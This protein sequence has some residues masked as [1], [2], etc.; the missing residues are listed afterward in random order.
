MSAIVKVKKQRNRASF[1][2][3]K[4]KEKKIKCDRSQPCSNC[5]KSRHPENCTYTYKVVKSKENDNSKTS[6]KILQIIDTPDSNSKSENT[7]PGSSPKIKGVNTPEKDEN[8]FLGFNADSKMSILHAPLDLQKS[9]LI[10]RKPSRT[11]SI[12]Y[13]F[14]VIKKCRLPSF[15]RSFKTYFDNERDIW[16]S[17]H[18]NRKVDPLQTLMYINNNDEISS[19]LIKQIEDL[20]CNNYYAVLERLNYFQ[21]HLNEVLF[22]SYIPM[23]V[24]QLIFHHYFIMKPEG[25]QFKHVSKNFEYSFIAL[26]A[27]IVSLTDVFTKNGFPEFNFTLTCGSSEYDELTINLLNSFNF[28]KKQSVFIVYTLLNLRLSLMV[29]GNTQSN[30]MIGQN[31]F[32]YFQLAVNIAQEI[33]LNLDQDTV[34]YWEPLGPN[35]KPNEL[36]FAQEIPVESFKRLWNCILALDATYCIT[37]YCPPLIDDRYNHG[38]YSITS[39]DTSYLERFVSTIR[40]TSSLFGVQKN[41]TLNEL[42]K[43]ID[44]I[45]KLIETLEPLKDFKCIENNTRKWE[46]VFLK[47]KL[48]KYYCSLNIYLSTLLL[49]EHLLEYYPKE[50]VSIPENQKII[51]VLKRQALLSFKISY[52]IGSNIV[53]QMSENK[54]SAMFLI[55]TR[56]ILSDW[57]GFETFVMIFDSI[58]EEIDRKNSSNCNCGTSAGTTAL[59][60]PPRFDIADLEKELFNVHRISESKTIQ[61]IERR[62]TS[63]Y[64][65]AYITDM[66]EKTIEIPTVLSDY[67]FFVTTKMLLV[68]IYFLYCHIKNFSN[69][70]FLATEN[71]QKLLDQTR[72]MV[73]H[74]FQNGA[75]S[76]IV[77]TDRLDLLP[78]TSSTNGS[79]TLDSTTSENPLTDLSLFEPSYLDNIDTQKLA[80]MFE[81]IN[82]LFFD[83]VI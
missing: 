6:K 2:C 1:V 42:L 23:G 59:P 27:S 29:Y 5:I 64:L 74:F 26:I 75:I 73:K 30:G 32:S 13:M 62:T 28:R 77:H 41:L 22:N 18:F 35:D 72:I 11:Q 33:G 37:L 4:C 38:V 34:K 24:V 83:Q 81:E 71:T 43:H 3:L 16:K 58:K 40:K 39:L 80:T 49:D 68:S 46:N 60:P 12:P 65:A 14:L 17:K 20:I 79:S 78:A 70:I 31:S 67:T 51:K 53:L 44:S 7:E 19:K 76:H 56:N 8:L 36:S 15:I 21:L 50:I 55:Y 66:Y 52:L 48:L 45:N 69:N 10:F 25:I 54:F 61:Y 9:R 63:I 82:Q 57:L 47:L